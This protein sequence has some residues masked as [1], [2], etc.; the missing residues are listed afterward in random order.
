[1]ETLF[2]AHSGLR[3]LVLLAGVV[4]LAWF[5]WGKLAGRP[6]VRPAPA[7]LAAFTGLF[8]LQLLLGLALLVGGRRPPAVWGHV[9]LMLSAAVVLHVLGRVHKRRPE[10]RGHGLP[11]LAVALTLVFV[12]VGILSIGRAIV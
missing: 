5:G 6:F 3:Y 9:A 2:A 7:L 10:P 4:A 8:D 11:L 1:M 12:V